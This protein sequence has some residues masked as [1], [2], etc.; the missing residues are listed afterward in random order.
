MPRRERGRGGVHEVRRAWEEEVREGR[1]EEEGELAQS[2]EGV[3]PLPLS[4]SGGVE[5]GAG[6]THHEDV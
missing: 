6:T 2:P 5:W 1:R 3:V 4:V